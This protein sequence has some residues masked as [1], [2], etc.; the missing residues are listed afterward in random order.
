LHCAVHLL[1][2]S[3]DVASRPQAISEESTAEASED[4]GPSGPP[5][6]SEA[7]AGMEPLTVS[8][9]DATP[10]VSSELTALY[11]DAHL[12]L[13]R[14]SLVLQTPESNSSASIWAGES[15]GGSQDMCLDEG[16]A[17]GATTN[18]QVQVD[19]VASLRAVMREFPSPPPRATCAIL[20]GIA[21]GPPAP[22]SQLPG[23]VRYLL[24][25]AGARAP[26]AV[27]FL[28]CGHLGTLGF[29][30]PSPY[31]A[32][33]C[34]A[35][36]FEAP[37]GVDSVTSADEPLR[38]HFAYL[39]L[40][41]SPENDSADSG[42][43]KDEATRLLERTLMEKWEGYRCFRVWRH[44]STGRIAAV[45]ELSAFL[46]ALPAVVD[47]EKPFPSLQSL[48]LM[49]LPWSGLLRWLSQLDGMRTCYW[50]DGKIEHLI[51]LDGAEG[52]RG[53]D[54]GQLVHCELGSDGYE[55]HVRACSTHVVAGMT[56]FVT[57]LTESVA[58]AI[59]CW[60]WAA[61]MA[62]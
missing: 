29:C 42:A 35:W 39:L 56:G 44:L 43:A 11:Y 24:S 3:T 26:S 38:A 6:T 14:P 18:A 45:A 58:N 5:A 31:D 52:R 49:R 40:R 10:D 30:L 4:R 28:P 22:H 41:L 32:Y 61:S 60:T 59:A 55:L 15:I 25:T 9:A 47:L 12:T 46:G 27:H 7:K 37:T 16:I 48:G 23:Y 36:P 1:G 21:Q 53:S 62:T 51:V 50:R 57:E 13:C 19:T 33:E 17:G 34:V 8:E 20:E 54:G 2:H